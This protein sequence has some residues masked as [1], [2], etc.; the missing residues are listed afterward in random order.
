MMNANPVTW[1][2]LSVSDLDRAKQFYETVFD[3]RLVEFPTEWGRQAAFPS[4]NEGPN[5]SGALVEK[6]DRAANGNNT[7]VYFA[8]KECA[9]EE[10]R[11]EKAGGSVITPKMPIG[12]FGF[13]SIIMDTEGN[14]IG[15]HSRE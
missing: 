14:I 12:E 9:A 11:V 10:Q 15:L 1:F 3:I 2:D 13:V 4:D 8:T 5:A 6:A 7:I